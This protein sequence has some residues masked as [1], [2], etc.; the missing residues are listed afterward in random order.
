MDILSAIFN[1]VSAIAI[2]YSLFLTRRSIAKA[3]SNTSYDRWYS[4]MDAVER[5]PGAIKFFV[6]NELDVDLGE[7]L[8]FVRIVD[9]YADSD[10]SGDG[11]EGKMLD[12]ILQTETGRKF[13]KIAR[14]GFYS[15]QQWIARI[16]QL[17]IPRATPSN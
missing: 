9:L 13:W 6:S 1:A 11:P 12:L 8:V 14:E 10:N 17:A 2:V 5:N 3:R 4:I 15:D 7:F 16:D